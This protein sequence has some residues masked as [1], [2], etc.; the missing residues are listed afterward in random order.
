MQSANASA[1]GPPARNPLVQ[2]K[3]QPIKNFEGTN[4]DLERF[5]R[6][7][8]AHFRL[9]RVEDDMDCILTAGMLLEDRAADWYGAYI[10]KVEPAEARRVYGRPVE[11]DPIYKSWDKFEASIPNSFG[12]R[13]DRDAAVAEWNRL[14]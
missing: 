11:L 14:H 3:T 5:L 8:K 13:I 4:G 7:L 10:C 12:G 2:A 1:N 6:A 9:A